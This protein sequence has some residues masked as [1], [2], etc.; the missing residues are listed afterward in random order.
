MGP[1]EPEAYEVL[2]TAEILCAR[3]AH[4]EYPDPDSETRIK[5][6]GEVALLPQYYY[7]LDETALQ[8][9]VICD[10]CGE[11]I[12][13]YAYHIDHR[14]ANALLN[15]L[16]DDGGFTHKVVDDG[17]GLP[18]VGYWVAG[19]SQPFTVDTEFLGTEYIEEGVNTIIDNVR[20]QFVGGWIS[21]GIVYIE[22]VEWYQDVE[23]AIENVRQFNQKAIYDIANHRDILL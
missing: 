1:I 20:P 4:Q 9:S 7:D 13:E 17:C 22:A 11:T 12:R 19:A 8:D 21:N 6:D 15:Q 2:D 10:E 23:D 3:C 18:D 5:T 16:R 14:T